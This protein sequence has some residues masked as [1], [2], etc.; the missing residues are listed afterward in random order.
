MKC[1][2]AQR[3]I[4]LSI[5]GC[6]SANRPGRKLPGLSCHS[7]PARK[8]YRLPTEA[9]E[10]KY[11]P[12]TEAGENTDRLPTQHMRIST[13]HLRRPVKNKDIFNIGLCTRLIIKSLSMCIS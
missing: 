13:G 11:R 8:K 12:P 10:D 7:L 2:A 1:R 9:G 3:M 4:A 6:L 5:A